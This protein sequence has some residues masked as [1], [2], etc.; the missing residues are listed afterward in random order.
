MGIILKL[1]ALF[2]VFLII[3]TVFTYIKQICLSVIYNYNT[4]IV[5]YYTNYI[6]LVFFN[7]AR[8]VFSTCKIAAYTR[9]LHGIC[10]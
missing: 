8:K 5:I 1:L 7:F 10:L 6:L 9:F 4:L 3:I 2:S